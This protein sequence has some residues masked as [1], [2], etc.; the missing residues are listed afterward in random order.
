M[1]IVQVR[2]GH[3]RFPP[4]VQVQIPYQFVEHRIA[5]LLLIYVSVHPNG[6]F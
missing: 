5:A 4:H 6:P 3:Q 1:R 2:E